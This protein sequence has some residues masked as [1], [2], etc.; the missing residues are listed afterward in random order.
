MNLL[1]VLML[2][3]L[4]GALITFV[5]VRSVPSATWMLP[6]LWQIIFSLGVFSS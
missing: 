2:L 3:P 1:N 6:G 4:A 5:L